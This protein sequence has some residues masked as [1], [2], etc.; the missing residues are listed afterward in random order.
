MMKFSILSR[1]DLLAGTGGGAGLLPLSSAF[2]ADKVH[3]SSG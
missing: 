3:H 1:R 2:A